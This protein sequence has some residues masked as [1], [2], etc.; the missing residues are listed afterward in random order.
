MIRFL[1]GIVSLEKMCT[2]IDSYIRFRKWNVNMKSGILFYGYKEF[3]NVYRNY[4]KI[5]CCFISEYIK[6]AVE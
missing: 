2:W 1:S 3:F 6:A 5:H 4:L